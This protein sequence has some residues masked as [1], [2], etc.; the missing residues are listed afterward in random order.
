MTK[1]DD[2]EYESIDRESSCSSCDDAA[3][4]SSAAFL[5]FRLGRKQSYDVCME[6][7]DGGCYSTVRNTVLQSSEEYA[8]KI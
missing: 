6:R 4:R 7:A 5:S 1:I 2:T 8:G 3:Q